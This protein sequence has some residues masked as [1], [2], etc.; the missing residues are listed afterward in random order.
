[1][2]LIQFLPN[3]RP[4]RSPAVAR[5]FASMVHLYYTTAGLALP[6]RLDPFLAFEADGART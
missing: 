6:D 5:T 4:H 2:P 3:H 1:M